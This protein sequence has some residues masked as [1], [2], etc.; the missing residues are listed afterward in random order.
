MPVINRR[1]SISEREWVLLIEQ[2]RVRPCRRQGE[3]PTAIHCDDTRNDN[4]ALPQ[5]IKPE[6]PFISERWYQAHVFCFDKNSLLKRQL[7]VS[8]DFVDTGPNEILECNSATELN[9][10][11][12]L[13]PIPP[14]LSGRHSG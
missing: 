6:R 3:S 4:E 14:L 10:M 8:D 1:E 12:S 7:S 13:K 5:K 9:G 11:E 2:D